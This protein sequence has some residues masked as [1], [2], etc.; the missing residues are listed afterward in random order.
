[1]SAFTLGL[2]T[3]VVPFSMHVENRDRLVKGMKEAGVSTGTILLRGG[4]ASE[5]DDTDHENLFRQESY[6]HYLFGVREPG[7]WGSIDISTGDATLYCP[8]LPEEYAVW[9]GKISTCLEFKI[10]YEVQTVKYSDNLESSLRTSVK[11]IFVNKGKNSDS[12]STYNPP[13]LDVL[14]EVDC[15]EVKLFPVLCDCRVFKSEKELALMAH[16]SKLTSLSHVHVMRSVTPGM[17]EYQL[18]A[19]FS[20]FSYYNYGCRNMGY[21]AICACGPNPA[22]LHYGHA[23][24]PNDRVIREEDMLLLDMGAEYHCYG[25]DITCSYPANG[26][27]TERQRKVYE[28]VLNAQRAVFE[29]CKPGTSWVDC[30]KAAEKE[31]IKA[32]IDLKVLREVEGYTL[33]DMV[34]MR[35]GGVFMPHGLGHHIG[36]D[37]HDVGGYLEGGKSKEE[38]YPNRL[39]GAGLK[40]LRNL[41]ILEEH[42]C[43]TVEPGCYFI[44]YT[45]DKAIA[46]NDLG[47]FIDVEVVAE[48]RGTGGVR[49]EDVI[50]ITADGFENYTLAPRGIEEV[51]AV[52]GG[53]KWPPMK[54][55]HPELMRKELLNM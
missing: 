27:F 21:T 43:L 3:Y 23:G 4:T 44:D 46:D 8:R 10:K 38:N 36:I 28:G 35:L 29:I 16:V 5:R 34:E 15:D 37:T 12:G 33:E 6:F 45:I 1:M 51:E 9:M 53:A 24:A 31:V 48:F 52:M 18:E 25:S 13:V 54:D 42:Q 2:N 55:V 40:S 14:K 22:V 19:N 49:L 47:K 39:K 7:F 32:L 30:H 20:H 17:M 26:K 50:A 11:P 41:R